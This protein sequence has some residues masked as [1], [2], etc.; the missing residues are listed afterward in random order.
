MELTVNHRIQNIIEDELVNFFD[1][2]D[3]NSELTSY[4]DNLNSQNIKYLTKFIKSLIQEGYQSEEDVSEFISELLIKIISESKSSGLISELKEP[5]LKYFK[6]QEISLSELINGN[7]V[8]YIFTDDLFDYLL[9][10]LKTLD[11]DSNYYNDIIFVE[12]NIK[13]EDYNNEKV[14]EKLNNIYPNFSNKNKQE[15]LKTIELSLPFIS[16]LTYSKK[17]EKKQIELFLNKFF[18]NRTVANRNVNL[19]TETINNSDE[20]KILVKFLSKIYI[21]TNGSIAT[22]KNYFHTIANSNVTNRIIVNES[23]IELKE[24]YKFNLSPLFDIILT[25]NA[26]E[27]NTFKLLKHMFTYKK[28]NKYILSDDKLKN[29]T[30]EMFNLVFNDNEKANEVILFFEGLTDDKRIKEIL[31][32]IISGKTKEEILKLS[33]K[34]LKF[35]FD[36]ITENDNIFEYQNDIEILK[37]IAESGEKNH[38]SKLTKVIVSKLQKEETID[39][40]LT[41]LEISKSFNDRD[42]RNIITN[43]ENILEND[44][45]K[46]RVGNIINKL[47]NNDTTTTA[48]SNAGESDKIENNE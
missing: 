35:S 25:D 15:I 14:F 19:I 13:L 48:I 24:N 16:P 23:F 2:V 38:L 10:E 22:I 42:S 3:I 29:K 9:S 34:L 36:R 4:I 5:F 8:P 33:T 12:N 44:S 41:I 32:D 28:D 40:A 47:K 17:E 21:T 11:V 31:S 1:K 18:S 26:Y 7:K 43:L 20:I 39:E 37:A 27:K 46:E 30:I 6:S 45:Y